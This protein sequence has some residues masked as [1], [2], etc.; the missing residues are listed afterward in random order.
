[1]AHIFLGMEGSATI[2]EAARQA[3][4]YQ[5]ED[6]CQ[7]EETHLRLRCAKGN[8]NGFVDRGGSRHGCLSPPDISG[9]EQPVRIVE[10]AT[11]RA[12]GERISRKVGIHVFHNVF[13]DVQRSRKASWRSFKTGVIRYSMTDLAPVWM[14][15]V[16]C[17]PGVMGR[18]PGTSPR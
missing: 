10:S 18:R 17:I 9:I 14:S 3:I 13:A 16:A 2:T 12:Y 8:F 15:T 11:P 4:W 7:M 5:P 1:M 6:G